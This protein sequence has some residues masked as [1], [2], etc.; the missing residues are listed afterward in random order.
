LADIGEIDIWQHQYDLK[1]K[2]VTLVGST[3]QVKKDSTS[4][5]NVTYIGKG[6]RGLDVA[7]TG[8]L[9][10]KIDKTT[11]LDVTTAIDSWNNRVGA[12]YG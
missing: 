3:L 6:A 5:S 7:S 8:W 1:A 2:R 10:T 9:L 12:T 4:T 11:E